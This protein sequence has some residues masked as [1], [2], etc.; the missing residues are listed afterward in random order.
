M[1]AFVILA[2]V[3]VS[4]GALLLRSGLDNERSAYAGNA[5]MA[6]AIA[7]LMGIV[8]LVIAALR[9]LSS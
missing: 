7:L 6:G 1:T 2:L 4:G 9:W 5:V 8:L 3:L